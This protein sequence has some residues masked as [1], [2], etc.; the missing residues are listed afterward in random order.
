LPFSKKLLLVEEAQIL[1]KEL[2]RQ[3]LMQCS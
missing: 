1:Q 2:L 3:W